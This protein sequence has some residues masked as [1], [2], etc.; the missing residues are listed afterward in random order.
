LEL[1]GLTTAILSGGVDRVTVEATGF[2]TQV[3]VLGLLAG[4]LGGATLIGVC[5]VV[6]RLARSLG[7]GDPFALGGNALRWA[8]WIVLIGGVLASV[9][10]DLG[11]WLA[12]RELFR[13]TGWSV[14]G[15]GET[16]SI[17]ELGWPEPSNLSLTIPF[18]PLGAALVL[19]LLAGV[20]RYGGRL[21]RDTEGL[22]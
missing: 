17:A 8:A 10:G 19:A 16:S 14:I 1:D 4:V 13:V 9:V 11:D 20:F 22:V 7:D 18:W 6:D 5:L 21:R 3:R 2:S 15:A 12:S